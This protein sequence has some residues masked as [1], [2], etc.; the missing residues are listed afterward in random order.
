LFRQTNAHTDARIVFI[1]VNIVFL[2]VSYMTYCC[3]RSDTKNA[4][5]KRVKEQALFISLLYL[6]LHPSPH[7]TGRGNRFNH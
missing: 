4:V 2:G 6:E 3:E 5:R 1:F 7:E